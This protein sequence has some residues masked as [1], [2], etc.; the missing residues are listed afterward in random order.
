M[1]EVIEVFRTKK[2]PILL[3]KTAVLAI[4]LSISTC[5][6]TMIDTSDFPDELLKGKL[7]LIHKCGDFDI[8]NFRG[9]TLLP[10]LSKVFEE[11]L[12]RQLY[13]YLEGIDLFVGNQ[14][15]FLKDSSC[16]SAALQLVDFIKSNYK[17]KLVAVMFIDLK[18]AFDTVD[19][20]RLVRKLKRQGLSDS[21]TKLMLSYLQ[22]RRTATSIGT[23]SSNFRNVNVGVAQGSK[24]GPLHFIIYINDMLNLDLIGELVL[25]ADDAALIYA[26]VS[27][28][29]L[30]NAM[31]HD[32]DML[33]EWLCRNV[34]SLNA[35][36]TCYV[37]FGKA[38]DI[39]DMRIVVDGVG[40]GRVNKYKYLGLVIDEDLKFHAHVD[41]VKKQITPFI[42]KF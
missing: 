28:I 11:L 2:V 24:L 1:T 32:A 20:K 22:N 5:F 25:Y 21:A 36:K 23:N 12:L 18:K 35:A 34:L 30:Q 17:K 39:A 3:L 4:A 15:G 14:F 7:K 42:S 27:A 33:H 29:D 31:Q 10:S 19:P 26:L 8:D 37:Y 9:L 41:H 40:I 13:A 16:Q 38:K 6:N